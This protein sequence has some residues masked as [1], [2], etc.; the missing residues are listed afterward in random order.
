MKIRLLKSKGEHSEIL[1][2]IHL[3]VKCRE[4][5]EWIHEVLKNKNIT[6]DSIELNISIKK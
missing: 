3:S 6:C 1:R 5:H 2:D 4:F